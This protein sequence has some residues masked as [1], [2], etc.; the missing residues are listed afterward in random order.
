[1]ANDTLHKQ[2]E[3]EGILLFDAD[4]D[5]DLDIYIAAGGYEAE[6]N[7]PFY[8]DRLYVN[9][10]SGHFT[11]DSLALPKNY[12]SKF[13]VRAFDYDNDGDLDVFVSGRVEPWNY[14]KPV[15]SYILRNDSKKGIV[16]FTNVT[17]SVSKDLAQIGLICDAICSDFDNDGW[18][19]LILAGEW[20]PLC[21]LKN[22][23]GVFEN[24]TASSGLQN[25]YGF[26]NSLAA[27]D[28]DND[29]DIDYIAG[30]LGENSFYKATQQYPVYI[31]AKDFDNNASFDAFPSLYLPTSMQDTQKREYPA[32]TRDDVV[33]Q[34]ISMRF[35]FQNY[36]SFA[37]ATMDSVLP[38]RM[39]AG[40]IR[41]KANFLSSVF[42]KNNG[43]AHFTITPLP[44]QAQWSVLCGML[45]EDVD[46]DGNLDII[47]NGND[48]GT[49][50]SVGRYDALHG[51]ILKGNGK[52]NFTS[53][54]LA[55]SGI[56]I[57][58]N[59]K[60]LVKLK[61]SKENYLIAASQNKDSLLIFKP[62]LKS[63]L[64]PS[65]SSVKNIFIFYK[66]GNKQKKELYYG[67]SYLSQSA[68]FFTI[69]GAVDF[70]EVN[71]KNGTKEK[72]VLQ[73][74]RFIQKK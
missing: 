22:N 8:Q 11:Y 37:M 52:G 7:T 51:L 26:W 74:N 71:Y 21:F 49:E 70:I 43:N 66:N 2:C 1:L 32:Q 44:P 36:K 41:L 31:T 30:N 28:F 10:G 56:F 25:E 73:N 3:D 39:R 69:N 34:M 40:A 48:Y 68:A 38:S 50:V 15:S 5:N 47:I 59:G 13:C 63:L 46:G 4:S 72:F 58:H 16:R 65:G 29:G 12:T 42:I 54:S 20:M 45:V 14:P 23:K 60:A 67:S 27:G 6:P 61:T 53:L 18:T 19:D 17:N 33:K 62:K 57:P 55:E 64:L 24:I 9:D 35:R